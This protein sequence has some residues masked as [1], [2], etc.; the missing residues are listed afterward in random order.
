MK[1]PFRVCLVALLAGA[2]FGQ[3]PAGGDLAGNL[4]GPTVAKIQGRTVSSTAP[5][6]G[7]A[8]LWNSTTSTWTPGDIAA[9]AIDWSTIT[10]KPTF[11]STNT[12]SA[13]VQRDSSGNFSAGTVTA[14][15]SGNATTATTAGNVTG[16]VAP[17]NGGTGQTTLALGYA[18]LAA[19]QPHQMSF[20]WGDGVNVVTALTVPEFFYATAYSITVT[21]VRCKTIPS[22]ATV[23]FSLI[24][25]SGN[26]M[27]SA[28]LACTYAGA[29]TTSMNSSYSTI[30]KASEG[31]GF[32]LASVSAV[33]AVAVTITYTRAY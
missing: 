31:M 15:L 14:A 11:A 18:A 27:T 30:T 28:V 13:V 33:T 12:A 10:N 19:S 9:S 3:V 7:Q 6:N 21:G 1:T 29:P 24:D 25:S 20:V 4:P 32:T 22:G 17:A 23:N 16:V 8:L 5:T 26:L 2:V